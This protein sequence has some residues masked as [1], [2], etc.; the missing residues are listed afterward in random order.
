MCQGIPQHK[1]MVLLLFGNLH[2][3]A[4]RFVCNPIFCFISES[5][6]P[7]AAE[8]LPPVQTFDRLRFSI[9]YILIVVLTK[10][11]WK[12]SVGDDG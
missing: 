8:R 11:H 9:R 2:N 3:N 6:E 10:K 12:A 1:P 5:D 7:R 4:L